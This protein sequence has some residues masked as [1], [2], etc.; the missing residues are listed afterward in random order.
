VL[1]ICMGW[2]KLDCPN[3][4]GSTSSKYSTNQPSQINRSGLLTAD[5][6]GT[7]D[8]PF[9]S[10]IGALLPIALCGRTSSL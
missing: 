3:N 7:A 6:G 5:G 1:P 8:E 9:K 2:Q 10:D 4:D